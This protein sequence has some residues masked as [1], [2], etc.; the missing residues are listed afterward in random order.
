MKPYEKCQIMKR[1][2]PI[3]LAAG[4]CSFVAAEEER[5]LKNGSIAIQLNTKPSVAIQ[6]RPK[7]S[8]LYEKSESKPKPT[9][10]MQLPSNWISA[11]S[12]RLQV[13][14]LKVKSPWSLPAGEFYS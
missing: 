9:E 6:G 3:L 1:T 8:Y 4:L 13:T 7:I 12:I 10:E 11:I 5:I 2:L 14:M